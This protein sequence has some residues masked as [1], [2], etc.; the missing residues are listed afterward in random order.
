MYPQVEPSLSWGEEEFHLSPVETSDES[1][2]SLCDR[3]ELPQELAGLRLGIRDGEAGDAYRQMI[4]VEKGDGELKIK[5]IR[6]KVYYVVP[7][8]TILV[9]SDRVDSALR[10]CFSFE[11]EPVFNGACHKYRMEVK[12]EAKLMKNGDTYS[13]MSNGGQGVICL[14]RVE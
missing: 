6:G 8:K 3:G 1:E 11:P 9:E 2:L 12:R 7:A 5:E 4:I 14:E 10:T 13:P